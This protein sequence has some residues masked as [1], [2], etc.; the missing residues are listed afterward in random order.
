M[1][2]TGAGDVFTAAFLV[3]YA[4]TKDIAVATRYA[5]AAASFVVEGIGINNL[6]TLEQIEERFQNYEFGI[7]S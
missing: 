7:R 3:K 1:D 4:Q 5:H 2:S 6:A